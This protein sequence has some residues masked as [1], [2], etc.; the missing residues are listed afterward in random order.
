MG[1]IFKL[2]VSHSPNLIDFEH[3][4]NILQSLRKPVNMKNRV[5]YQ[6][7]EQM[8]KGGFG[9]LRDRLDCRDGW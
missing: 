6:V 7:F 1:L 5:F 2:A 8:K 4:Q 3:A 9:Q